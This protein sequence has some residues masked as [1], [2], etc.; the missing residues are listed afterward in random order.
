MCLN[1]R[2]RAEAPAAPESEIA[3]LDRRLQARGAAAGAMTISLVWSG[4]D[5]V[6]L[7]VSCPSGQ[8]ADLQRRP[9]DCG[10]LLDVDANYPALIAVED[11]VE[12]IHFNTPVPGRYRVQVARLTDVPP[13]GDLSFGVVLRRA[14]TPEQRREGTFRGREKRWSTEFEI[15]R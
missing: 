6:D 3:D 7:R 15:S 11:P 5:D 14:G 2:K 12:N 4:R 10:G 9:N 13:R 1:A 8:I